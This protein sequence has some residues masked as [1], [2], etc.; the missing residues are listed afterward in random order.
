M[1]EEGLELVSSRTQCVVSLGRADAWIRS[2]HDTADRLEIKRL[3][4][5]PLPMDQCYINLAIIE[6]PVKI[7]DR[8]EEGSEG[9]IAPQ[10]SPVS[11]RARLKVETPDRKLQLEL[12]TIF[13]PR[14]GRGG[15]TTQPRRIMIRGY[16]GVGKTTL[17]EA[18]I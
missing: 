9:N 11:L 7:I 1:V 5:K 18:L 16:A 14:K 6:Q 15:N 4:G 13:N 17:S 12:P 2:N 8:S 10:S 3:S